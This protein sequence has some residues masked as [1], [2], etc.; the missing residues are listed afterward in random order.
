MESHGKFIGGLE[1]TRL[2]MST[3]GL[4]GEFPL[5]HA[6]ANAHVFQVSDLASEDLGKDIGTYFSHFSF[7]LASF[8]Q[9]LISLST[10]PTSVPTK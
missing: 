7:F 4:P 9:Q 3:V 1:P 6:P 8:W 5:Q 2:N 10:F